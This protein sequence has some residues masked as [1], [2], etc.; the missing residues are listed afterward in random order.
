LYLLAVGWSNRLFLFWSQA[1]KLPTTDRPFLTINAV[2]EVLGQVTIKQGKRIYRR[3]IVDEA[4]RTGRL[5]AYCLARG[6]RKSKYV[7]HPDDLKKFLEGCEYKE[8][9]MDE[10][11]VGRMREHGERGRG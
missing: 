2:C 3:K 1:M 9:R 4:I 6:K 7:V 11:D 8:S 10:G 5:K